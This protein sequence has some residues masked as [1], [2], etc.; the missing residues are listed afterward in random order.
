MSVKVE[1]G[2][3]QPRGGGPLDR[4]KSCDFDNEFD[5]KALAKN[6][7]RILRILRGRIQEY[8]CVAI[9]GFQ[10]NRKSNKSKMSVK[11][12]GGPTKGGTLRKTKKL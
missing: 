6:Q 10:K 4:P 1:G 8:R 11:V 5:T 12:E 7:G 3:V 2:E 9:I